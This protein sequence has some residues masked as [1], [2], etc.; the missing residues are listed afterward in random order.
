MP[1]IKASFVVAV[2]NGQAFLAQT[3]EACLK[4][5]EK[6]IEVVVVDDGST[7]NTKRIIDYY[8]AKDNR[9]VPVFLNQNTGRSHARNEGIKTAQGDVIL[10]SDA[11]DLPTSDRVAQTLNY[12][13]KNPTVDIVYG[14]FNLLDAMGRFQ[15]GYDVIPFDIER[16]KADKVT[17]I[18][19]STMAFKKSVF[20][21]VQYVN[22]DVSKL[23]I[24]D[25]YF[26]V[27]AHKAGF[28]FGAIPKLLAGYR[29]IPKERDE[30]K[31]MEIKSACLAG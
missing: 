2:Y 13:K 19:H 5:T 23:G 4:Q 22:G 29:F 7:D 28:R 17:Y 3:L 6:K 15:E 21:K 27:S 12:M 16:V 20:E 9:V 31:V 30:K 14:Q 25:W 24:D 26:Q 1:K 8:A 10:I 11:D 18:C